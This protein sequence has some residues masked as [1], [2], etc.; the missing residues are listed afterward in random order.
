M[1]GLPPLAT[2]L[3]DTDDATRL[4]QVREFMAGAPWF[5]TTLPR[6]GAPEALVSHWS[7]LV[8]LPLAML[9]SVFGLVLSPENAEI[10]VR[11]VWPLMLLLPL[12]YIIARAGEIRGGRSTAFFALLLTILAFAAIVQFQPGRIDHHNVMNLAVTAGLLLL[13]HSFNDVRGASTA[14]TWAGIVLGLGLAVGYESLLVTGA[15][16]AIAAILSILRRRDGQNVERAGIAFTATLAVAFVLTT[17][18]SR[19]LDVTCDALSLNIVLLSLVCVAGLALVR[20]FASNW[21]VTAR[22]GALAA[23]GAVA[24]GVFAL[25]EPQCLAGPFGQVDPAVYPIWLA[26]VSETR[27]F[28]WLLENIPATAIAFALHVLVGLTAATWI[29]HRERDDAALFYTAVLAAAAVL[30]MAQIKLMPYAAILSILPVAIVIAR[31]P[32]SEEVSATTLQF[33]AAALLN[34]KS[35]LLAG[36]LIAG[37]N[38]PATE[39]FKSKAESKKACLATASFTPLAGLP[40][41]LAVSEVD[42]GPYLVALTGMNALSAP[43]HR[44]DASIIESHAILRASPEDAKRRLASVGAS[45]VV[46]C[47]RLTAPRNGESTLAPDALKSLLIAGTPP[48]FLEPVALSGD[49]PLKVWRVRQ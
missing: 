8:D 19:W 1:S 20:R 43:Y 46:M 47:D 29:I 45:Y 15:G 30:A 26:H 49:T 31:I 38:N 10:A 11:A 18:P 33:G 16:L 39:A 17:P 36:A 34:Q 40:K 5:D 44:I 23:T 6:F 21:T 14:A 48:A 24:V 12:I 27:S 25:T 7:R 42:M 32:S 41:G 22:L 9:L 37:F 4:T 35:L 13:A 3:G 2:S 28:L